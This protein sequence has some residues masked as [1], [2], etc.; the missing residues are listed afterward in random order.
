MQIVAALLGAPQHGRWLIA[1]RN[2]AKSQQSYQHNTL[3]LETTFANS[4][5]EITVVDFMPEVERTAEAVHRTERSEANLIRIV[6][7]TR[8]TMVVQVELIVRFE[9]GSVE[10]WI[11]PGEGVYHFSAGPD[12]I[13][14]RTDIKIPAPKSFLL[15]HSEGIGYKPERW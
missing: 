3:I 14:L 7:C 8:G 2:A 11:D 10:P 6:R 13:T 1:P 15:P 9:Y 4:E 12:Q 5:G